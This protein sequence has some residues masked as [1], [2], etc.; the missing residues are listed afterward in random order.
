MIQ[1]SSLNAGLFKRNSVLVL[2]A[3]L[4]IFLI[5][6]VHDFEGTRGAPPEAA[7]FSESS[8]MAD[9]ALSSMFGEFLDHESLVRQVRD[10]DPGQRARA[11]AA[12]GSMPEADSRFVGVLIDHLADPDPGV[13]VAAARSLGLIGTRA[14]RAVPFLTPH[15]SAKDLVLRATTAFSL[16]DL[17]GDPNELEPVLFELLD[18]ADRRFA[19]QAA[20]SL[21][22]L[23][24][25]TKEALIR[26]E[27][28]SRT[29]DENVR[30]RAVLAM[31]NFGHL[32]DRGEAQD[33]VDWLERFLGD[34]DAQVR[35][36]AV[37][38]LG[39]LGSRARSARPTLEGLAEEGDLVDPELIRVVLE[40]IGA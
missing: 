33:L 17:R 24:F 25:P 7:G 26:L 2:G 36:Q 1:A 4:E 40:Q 23:P 9:L 5:L 20:V 13:Q 28:A 38:A 27:R 39:R 18:G 30:S 34:V 31:G 8:G 12:L 14:E 11:A 22:V 21:G 29:G 37:T 3:F 10:G 16:V 32:I 15:L 19:A 6:Q 35:V